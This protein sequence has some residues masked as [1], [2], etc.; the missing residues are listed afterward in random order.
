MEGIIA[1]HMMEL[2]LGQGT[3]IFYAVLL[4]IPLIMAFLSLTLEVFNDP[5]DKYHLG[6]SLYSTLS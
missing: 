4:L 6:H 5:L 3:L 1:R 2:T